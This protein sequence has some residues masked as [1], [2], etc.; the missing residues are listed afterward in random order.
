MGARA[1]CLRKPIQ[2]PSGRRQ[3]SSAA[4]EGG[5][6]G[7]GERV[8]AVWRV[9]GGPQCDGT[10]R[11]TDQGTGGPIAVSFTRALGSSMPLM[12]LRFTL[13]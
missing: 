2:A 9:L 11:V 7:A 3:A 10:R 8:G 1:K 13:T 4:R 6:V 5:I 12:K